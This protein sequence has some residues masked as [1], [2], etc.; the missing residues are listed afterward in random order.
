MLGAIGDHSGKLA[1]LDRRL[2]EL[3][4]EMTKK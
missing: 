3:A 2:D 4:V 1:R